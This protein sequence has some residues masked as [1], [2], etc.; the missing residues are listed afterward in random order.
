MILREALRA[1]AEDFREAG[2]DTPMLDAEVLLGFVLG[3]TRAGLVARRGD[4][5]ATADVDAFAALCR[6]RASREPVSHLVGAREFFGRPFLVNSA[7][8]TPRPETELLVEL[9]LEVIDAGA[10]RV[11]DVGTGSG[12]VALTLAAERLGL[13][14]LSVAAVDLSRAALGVA[15]ANSEVLLPTGGRIALLQGDLLGAVRA[16]VLDLV[17]SNPPYIRESLMAEGMPELAFEPK[18]A[19][20]GGDCDGLGVI[21]RLVRAAWRQLAPG[22]TLLFEIGAD[23]GVQAAEVASEVGFQQVVLLR[24]LAGLDRVIRA[25][26]IDQV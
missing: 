21:R 14:G 7:V 17:V 6:R 20:V 18:M 10:R 26:K 25:E 13:S 12:A 24:D 22:G 23:Q 2:C 16:G 8:L 3:H 4:L 9:A 11:V 19:L 1:A 5:I 15:A